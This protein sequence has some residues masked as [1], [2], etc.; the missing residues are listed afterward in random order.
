MSI[1]LSC[2]LCVAYLV[3][4]RLGR[5][6]GDV[7]ISQGGVG[8]YPSCFFY[9]ISNL[10]VQCLTLRLNFCQRRRAKE[11]RK[12]RRL[13]RSWVSLHLLY[14]LCVVRLVR[15]CII[16]YIISYIIQNRFKNS[17]ICFVLSLYHSRHL[18]C[19][20]VAVL[21]SNSLMPSLDR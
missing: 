16:S 4:L 7:V 15:S 12:V 11:R 13:S 10:F 20:I 3:C 9:L 2:Y 1:T 6:L 21:L 19:T 14:L 8:E 18:W 5:L 17:P